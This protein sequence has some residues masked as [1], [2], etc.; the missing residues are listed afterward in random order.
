[1]HDIEKA[2]EFQQTA[3]GEMEEQQRLRRDLE[4]HHQQLLAEANA[5]VQA[6]RN[7]Q[8]S[9]MRNELDELR[10]RSYLSLKEEKEACLL[11]VSQRVL[12]ESQSIARKALKDLAN[13]NLEHQIV[14]VF[15]DRLKHLEPF[16][17][18][19]IQV[20]DG[21]S[22]GPITV[23][24]S[25]PLSAELRQALIDQLLASLACNGCVTFI[26]DPLFPIGIQLGIEGKAIRWT[27]D[28]YLSDLDQHLTKALLP[29]SGS[30]H[31]SATTSA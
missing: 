25:F 7:D 27:L 10:H 22:N 16:E 21:K 3:Q 23:R 12:Q 4:A 13:A 6:Q 24:T 30:L 20:K 15:L 31:D 5:D 19:S 26:D 29:N 11:T 14:D 1:M 18:N 9:R 8:L 17:R 2:K 28:H